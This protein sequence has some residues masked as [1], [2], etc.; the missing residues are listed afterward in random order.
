MNSQLHRTRADA[1]VT[2]AWLERRLDTVGTDGPG[3]RVVEV[4]LNTEFYERGHV[5]GAVCID[6]RLELQHATRRDVPSRAS[7]ASLLGARGI[8]PETTLVLY[9][10]NSNWFAAHLYWLLTY[11]GHDEVYLL[12]GGRR[13]WL[14]SGRPTTTGRPSY[15]PQPYRPTGPFEHVR[16]YRSDIERALSTSTELVDVRLPDEFDGTILA[17]P[18]MTGSAQRGGH[19]PG[20]TNI[21]WSE[22]LRPDGRFKPTEILRD[23]YRSAG[24]DGDSDV[25]V[26]CRIGERSSLTWFVLSELLGYRS[27]RNYDGSWTEWGNLVGV[28]IAT[29]SE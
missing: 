20:A 26:Y 14:E 21:V 19:I 3:L 5:P 10:D 15:T 4:D 16:A 11:Y 28:P 13:H 22:N 17:P 29:G 12:D 2:P 7:F 6:W 9:G 25:I 8:T 1:V 24:I 27:V 23:R 18:G